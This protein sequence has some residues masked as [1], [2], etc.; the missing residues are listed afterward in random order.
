MLDGGG[1]AEVDGVAMGVTDDGCSKPTE[2]D[3]LAPSSRPS[4]VTSPSAVTM[5]Y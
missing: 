4:P 5:R 3:G 2:V 1:G